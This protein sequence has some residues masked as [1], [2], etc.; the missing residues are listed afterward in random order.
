[1]R[2]WQ[3][4]A[5]RSQSAQREAMGHVSGRSA[6]ISPDGRYRYSLERQLRE[7]VARRIVWVML[8]PSKADHYRDDATLRR[9]IWFSARYGCPCGAIEVVN[10]YAWRSTPSDGLTAA[11]ALGFDVI[12]PENDHHILRAFKRAEQSMGMVV[13]AWGA[14]ELAGARVE[15]VRAL[16]RVAGIERVHCLARTKEG[17][18]SHPLRLRS[19]LSFQPWEPIT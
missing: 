19:D 14:H 2:P 17:A 12:G 18:P 3:R 16:A 8:N 9:V 1:M 10:L 11:E 6:V 7:G 13:F 4:K 5:G 15:A